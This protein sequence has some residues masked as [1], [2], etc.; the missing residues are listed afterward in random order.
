MTLSDIELPRYAERVFDALGGIRGTS[1][2]GWLCKC[3]CREHGKGKGDQ[4]PS[5]R[6]SVGE[7]GRLLVTCRAGC[8]TV[9]VLNA[10]SLSWSDLFPDVNDVS[11]QLLSRE[12]E[13][14]T[15]EQSDLLHKVYTELLK[16]LKLSVEHHEDLRRRGLSDVSISSGGYRSL[17]LTKKNQVAS[18]LLKL[19]GDELFRVPGFSPGISDHKAVMTTK[20]EGLLIPVRDEKGRIVALKLRR[21][22][23]EAP[24]YV[25]I[26]GGE[27]GLSCGSPLHH[28]GSLGPN[29]RVK[30]LITEG[31]LKA[32]VCDEFGIE[33]RYVIG[34]PGVAQWRKAVLYAA[35]VRA[36]DVVVAFDWSDVK[37]NGAVFSATRDC[38]N[39][40]RGIGCD[41]GL[42]TWAACQKGID[43]LLIAGDMPVIIRGADLDALLNELTKNF[44]GLAPS[45]PDVPQ[46]EPEKQRLPFPTWAFPSVVRDFVEAVAA[47]IQCPVDF[48]AMGCLV[49]A[50][51]MA[52]SSRRLRVKKGWSEQPAMYAAMV[53]LPGS[54]KTPALEVVMRPVFDLQTAAERDYRASDEKFP[55]RH[56]FATDITVEGVAKRLKESHHGVLIFRDE[57]S[58]WVKSQDQYRGGKGADREFYLSAWSGSVVKKDR[59]ASDTIYV[60]YPFL[61]VLGGIQP[62]MLGEM[63]EK[64]GRNDGFLDRLLW[65]MPYDEELPDWSDDE[66]SEQ[67]TQTWADL[68]ARLASLSF[69]DEHDKDAIDPRDGSP[70]VVPFTAAAQTEWINWFNTNRAELRD[71]DFPRALR[72]PW[73]K[74]EAY[75]ARFALVL[76][77]MRDD[78]IDGR[79]P[80]GISEMK[81]AAA[82]ADYF[83]SHCRAVSG[84]LKSEPEDRYMD[85]LVELC[86]MAPD[87]TISQNKARQFLHLKTK[88]DTQEVLKRAVDL[89]L[90]E[91]VQVIAT[92]KK[93]VESF[94]LY[95]PSTTEGGTDV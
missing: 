25:Y 26:S 71:Q 37:S 84:H 24:K 28:A 60:P 35:T 56:Y 49:V 34:A 4:H 57:I 81:G 41:V 11:L 65:C 67:L 19:F 51:A 36:T 38:V 2:D 3:P 78:N 52:G 74:F 53:A 62:E 70:L 59:A 47:N 15:E 85:R 73:L 44:S 16:R 75:T 92:N 63:Q 7:E 33:G 31:E 13:P 40:L 20:C 27:D 90:G 29:D 64:K 95:A 12:T 22:D 77:L 39:D 1:P 80:V 21:P 91:M 8:T 18:T 9:E 30:L 42:A 58:G 5:V 72:G 55:L 48:P 86:M 68:V 83:K 17:V 76:N 6:V 43:D 10:A 69:V 23:S 46:D 14:L 87:R 61:T 32:D 79:S 82:L 66:I 93:R 45:G 50:G 54:R 94:Q 89:G 88:S